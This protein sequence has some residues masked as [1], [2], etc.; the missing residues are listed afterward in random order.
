MFILCITTVAARIVE[1]ERSVTAVQNSVVELVCE[2][3]GIPFPAITWQK[4][5]IELQSG[6]R[7]QILADGTLVINGVKVSLYTV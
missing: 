5:F 4:N 2:V 3:E 6:G 1:S 7:Y